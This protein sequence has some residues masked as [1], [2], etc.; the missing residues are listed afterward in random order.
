MMQKNLR[1][2]ILMLVLVFSL[3]GCSLLKIATQPFKNTISKVPEA[4][5]KS[6][7]RI[8]C[9]GEI[10]LDSFGRVQK[11]TEQYYSDEKNFS[12]KERRL[13]LREKISQFILNIQG[14]LLWFLIIAVVLSLSGFGWIVGAIF[15]GMRGVGRVAKE[16][17]QGI[18]NAKNYIRKNGDKYT[19]AE[20]KIYQKGLSDMMDKIGSSL[21]TK[22]SKKIVN[23]LRVEIKE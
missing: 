15:S 7:R 8:R 18:S 22:E 10:I 1:K 9:K 14:Y 4:T 21:S 19:D 6:Q 12:Q 16:L 3:S 17:V 23:K 11:C 20:L 13:S 2:S 5:E